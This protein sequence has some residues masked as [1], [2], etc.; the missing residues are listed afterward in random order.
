M[1]RVVLA[2]AACALLSGCAYKWERQADAGPGNFELDEARCKLF[3]RGMPQ[4]GYAFAGGGT[5]TA[6]AYAAAGAGV[7]AG[8]MGLAQAMQKVEDQ[9]NC[10]TAAGWHKLTASEEVARSRGN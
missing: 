6:G 4:Q 1:K 7:S 10:M 2:A 8:L 3:A 5:G 9:N